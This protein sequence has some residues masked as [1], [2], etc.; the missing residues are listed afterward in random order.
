MAN[1][2]SDHI[3]SCNIGQSEAHNR[4]TEA[5]LANLNKDRIYIRLDLMEKNELWTSPEMSGMDLQ[6][7][8]DFIARMVKE[9][10]GRAM[11]TKEWARVDKKTG[12]SVKINGSSPIREGVVV[13]KA[14]TTM[15]ELRRYCQACHEKWGITA[16][17]IHVH[18]DEGHYLDPNN[19][20]TW[21]PN[22]HAHIVWDWMN[23]ETGKSCKLGKEDMSLMQD[24]VAEALGM[25]RGVSK[26]ETGKRHLERNDYILTKQKQEAEEAT[27]AKT[28]AQADRDAAIRETDNAKEEQ[29]RLHLEIESKRQRD[30]E[31]DSEIAYKEELAKKA[32]K[33]NTEGI[34]SGF[35]NFFGKGKYAAIEK[36]NQE[37]RQSVPKE[38]QRLQ[39]W[40]SQ[41]FKEEIAKRTKT[42]TDQQAESERQYEEL[43]LKYN[44]LMGKYNDILK[45]KT[46]EY[47]NWKT[48]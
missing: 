18:R 34:I 2:T 6:A 10:T 3:K 24:M 37:L 38:K 23:H 40:Y 22:F 5:Y 33:E 25:E 8:Y 35:A 44:T 19:Q 46:E 20:S 4:R 41:T 17:Q 1:T 32:D 9:K 36:E 7:Y 21:A 43:R 39:E 11:Q 48:A 42:F 29:A 26:S 16:L 15:D 45:S 30:V 14:D 28:I 31:L 27:K 13:C 12:K 47:H